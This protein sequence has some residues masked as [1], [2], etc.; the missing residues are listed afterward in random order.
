MSHAEQ[1]AAWMRARYAPPPMPAATPA[2]PDQVAMAAMRDGVRLH[3]EIFLPPG[4]GPF[5]TIVCRAPYPM[6]MPSI[7]DSRPV[8]RY[9]EAGFAFVYQ[10]TRGQGPS[11]GRF[12]FFV[13]DVDDS[14][15][16]IHWLAAQPWCNGRVAMEGASYAGNVQWYAARR[17]PEALRCIM[18]TAFVSDFVKGPPQVGGIPMR[19][20]LLQWFNIADVERIDQ[21]DFMYLDMSIQQHPEWGPALREMPL[22]EAARD[23]ISREDKREACLEI[24][25]HLS[26]DAHWSGTHFR[27]EELDTVAELPA[28]ITAGWYDPTIG[29]LDF[30]RRLEARDPGRADRYLMV[31]PWEHAGAFKSQAHVAPIGERRV[32]ENARIDLIQPRIDFCRRYLS[33]EPDAFQAPRARLYITG[34]E[35]WIDADDLDGQSQTRTLYLHSQGRANGADGD[36]VLCEQAPVDAPAN[37]YR[38]DPRFPAPCNSQWFAERHPI[39]MR[40]DCL[41]FTTDAFTEPMTLLGEARLLLYA[42]TSAQDTDWIATLSEVLPDGRSLCFHGEAGGL[43]ARYRDGFDRVSLPIPGAPHRY[44]ISLGHCGHT[45]MPGTRLRLTINSAYAP[46][47]DPHPG[48]ADPLVGPLRG[49]IAEQTVFHDPQ[50]ASHLLLPVLPNEFLEP[51]A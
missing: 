35:R 13:D 8:S 33:D 36:G 5:P 25:D 23:R 12:R 45:L 31:G 40:S 44:Q 42:A 3:T 9:T 29:P 11:E 20:M 46:Y 17:R 32:P 30:Y 1:L 14:E 7:D 51:S 39:E 26:D 37:R 41:V 18:P 28:L 2:T 43:R 47:L 16:C 21:A 4:K 48:T 10:L 19:G 6:A 34:S 24:L 15:D 49:Q 22:A 38:H 50:R 27:D